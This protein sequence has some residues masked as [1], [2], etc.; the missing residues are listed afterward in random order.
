MSIVTTLIVFAVGGGI[1]WQ[2][3]NYRERLDVGRLTSGW[4]FFGRK[5]PDPEPAIV[6]ETTVTLAQPV[7]DTQAT[8]GGDAD[9]LTAI[10][11]IGPVYAA[12]LRAAG[13]AT[14]AAIAAA[15]ADQ[16]AAIVA[17]DGVRVPAVDDWIAQA[18]SLTRSDG[19]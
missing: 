16:L 12:R 5:S 4:R 10:H 18:Q 1:G 15:S 8:A 9:D 3:V 14:Y 17:P 13:L 7:A 2:L 6:E 19:A 11:G